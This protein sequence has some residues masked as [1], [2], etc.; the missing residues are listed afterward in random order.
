MLSSQTCTACRA[1][2]PKLSASD[3]DLLLKD[4]PDWT[5]QTIGGV[6]QIHRSFRFKNF[7]DA[8]Q[9]TNQVGAMAEEEGHHPAI[10]TEWGNVS[11]VWWTHKING[12]H[13]NDMICAAKTD[14]L[15]GEE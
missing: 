13:K 4:L 1:D 8:L 10:T 3:V 2:A 7:K 9:F 11:V 15:A 5:L 12:L 14:Q 6:D